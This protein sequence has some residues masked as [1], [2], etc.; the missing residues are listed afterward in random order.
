[1]E[2]SFHFGNGEKLV[3]ASAS[4]RRHDILK[5]ICPSLEIIPANVAETRKNGETPS[6][7]A[8]R[9]AMEKARSVWNSNRQ[10]VVVGAD[11]V[12][13]LDDAVF[14]KPTSREEA[15]EMLYYLAGRTHQVHTGVG[16]CF[17]K[18]SLSF[19]ETTDVTFHN[20]DQ[21]MIRWYAD[22]GEPMDKAGAYGIQGKGAF[23][24]KSISGDYLNVVGFPLSRFVQFLMDKG[25]ASFH[26]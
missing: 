26:E 20:V 15:V 8:E 4:P 17:A 22:T 16:I 9:L 10:M 12:V 14:G 21:Q 7:M 2:L 25:Y 11:T 1:M 3:L 13:S 18:K 5:Q 23:L 6:R 19:C 24:V